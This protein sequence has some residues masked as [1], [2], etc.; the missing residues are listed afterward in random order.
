MYKDYLSNYL[1]VC[2]QCKKISTPIKQESTTRY[3]EE[4]KCL[5]EP[6][7]HQRFELHEWAL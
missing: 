6:V 4:C 5:P 7:V 1:D 2:P 3:T